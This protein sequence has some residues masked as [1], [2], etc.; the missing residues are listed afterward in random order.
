MIKAKQMK[1][2]NSSPNV[3]NHR[4]NQS[5]LNSAR[6]MMRPVGS[7]HMKKSPITNYQADRPFSRNEEVETL[8]E[9]EDT[10]TLKASIHG[11]T[12]VV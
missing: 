11:D 10:Q 12:H 6:R 5:R 3:N 1:D 8:K 4:V 9:S 7:P 2:A